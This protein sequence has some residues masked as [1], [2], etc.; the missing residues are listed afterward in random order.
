MRTKIQFHGKWSPKRHKNTTGHAAR[1]T[2]F[3]C[4]ILEAGK[5]GILFL[6]MKIDA[7]NSTLRDEIK[8]QRV[9]QAAPDFE[10]LELGARL[11]DAKIRVG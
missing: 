7:D 9:A 5:G 8:T 4:E 1:P 6:Y 2:R 10:L 3:S 11:E